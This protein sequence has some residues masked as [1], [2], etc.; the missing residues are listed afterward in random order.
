M[1]KLPR[2]I[3]FLGGDKLQVPGFRWAPVSFMAAHG[4]SRGLMPSTGDADAVLTVHGLE[5]VYFILIFP[6]T[7]FERRKPWKLKD[8]ERFYKVG[9]PS[10]GPGSYTCD[11]LLSLGRTPRGSVGN[12]VAVLRD[13]ESHKPEDN[14]T[15][16]VRCE[17]KRR[18][19]IS[20]EVMSSNTG[21]DTVH[22]TQSGK[23]S[24]CVG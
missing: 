4:G 2:N 7:T 14:G 15:F 10:P 3:I 9:D 11:M 18:L 20:D 24:V 6:K 21:D 23:L 16:T 5:A 12:C 22:S 8:K 13:P 17:Y 1:A 19:I